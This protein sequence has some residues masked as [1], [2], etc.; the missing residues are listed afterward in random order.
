MM[1]KH[2]CNLCM[3]AKIIVIIG[4]LNWGLVGAFQ[5]DL[6]AELLGSVPMAARAVYVI[7]GL[8][9]LAMLLSLVKGCKFCCKNGSCAPG[10]QPMAQ[11]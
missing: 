1:G 8:A 9:G 4:A 5:F 10:S 3:V 7:V 11:Q 6:V 2:C